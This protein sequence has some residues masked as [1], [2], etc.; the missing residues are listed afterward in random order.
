MGKSGSKFLTSSQG[1]L[2]VCLLILFLIPVA[3]SYESEEGAVDVSLSYY[4]KKLLPERSLQRPRHHGHIID[5]SKAVNIFYVD[6]NDPDAGDGNPGTADKPFR[7]VAHAVQF[8]NGQKIPAKIIIRPGTYRENVLLAG[9][10]ASRKNDPVLIIEAEKKGTVFISGSELLQGWKKENTGTYYSAAW[11]Y[12]WGFSSLEYEEKLKY[13]RL[14]RRKELVSLNDTLLT[15]RLSRSELNAGSFF[16]DEERGKIYLH[17]PEHIDIKDIKNADIEV[18]VRTKIFEIKRRANF[19]LRGINIQHTM[20]T[21][22]EI[23]LR[24]ANVSNFLI[25]DCTVSDNA[26]TGILLVLAADGTLRRISSSNN[27][28]NGLDMYIAQSILVE[29]SE[30]S[31]NCWRSNQARVRHYF[32]AGAKLCHARNTEFRGNSFVGNL[33]RGFWIDINGEFNTFK[34]NLVMDNAGFGVFIETS[35]GPTRIEQNRI[36]GNKY[37][38]MI[39]ESWLTEL[40]AN[41]I[42]QNRRSQVG[43]RAIEDRTQQ[44]I[45]NR[46]FFYAQG[47]RGEHLTFRYLPMKLT[48]NNNILFSDRKEDVLYRHN[49]DLGTNFTEH[50]R[51]YRGDNNTFYHTQKKKIFLPEP[52][53]AN[54][55]LEQWQK[56][57]GQ[58]KQSQ[59]QE[60]KIYYVTIERKGK[61]L[62]VDI[63]NPKSKVIKVELYGAMKKNLRRED[64]YFVERNTIREIA[65]KDSPPYIFA[66]PTEQVKGGRMFFAKVLTE[67][68]QA[69]HSGRIFIAR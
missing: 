15:Q 60:P 9:E 23:A 42:F 2:S 50:I 6:C 17:P 14:G 40:V 53:S 27:G 52:V 7:T 64:S 56:K 34:E 31:Y 58:D 4:E 69:L 10:S 38:I 44:D 25:E 48:M 3:C 28:G 65:T 39:A 45:K 16:V 68:K 33:A 32:P 19:I 37:G 59:W 20:G 49:T 29:E 36:T 8:V 41:T 57:T 62:F 18:G 67:D 61:H 47:T 54:L 26:T 5:E 43:V 51:T 1:I 30:F 12:K 13:T 24:L 11:A 55:T 22:H 63:H 35:H 66:V 21:M 46:D